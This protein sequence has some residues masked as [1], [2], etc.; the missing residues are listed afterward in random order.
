MQGHS[1]KGKENDGQ[2]RETGRRTAS[3]ATCGPLVPVVLGTVH[4]SQDRCEL[5][6]SALARPRTRGP[7][8]VP[9]LSYATLG[10][11][12][13]PDPAQRRASIYPYNYI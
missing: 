7:Q 10:A 9:G 12:E 4:A 3:G 11:G 1:K 5:S 6:L 13:D 2:K 8:W